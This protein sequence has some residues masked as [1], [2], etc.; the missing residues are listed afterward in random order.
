M[1]LYIGT[2]RSMKIYGTFD[3]LKGK[4]YAISWREKNSRI[5]L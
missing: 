5:R 2:N 4:I 1:L 3:L